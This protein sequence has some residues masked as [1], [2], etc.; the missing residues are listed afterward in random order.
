MFT[1]SHWDLK[2]NSPHTMTIFS[3]DSIMQAT[4]RL[5]SKCT[6]YLSL[7]P[8]YLAPSLLTLGGIHSC[9][10]HSVPV[11]LS[12]WSI[13]LQMCASVCVFACVCPSICAKVLI[14]CSCCFWV[15]KTGLCVCI[16]RIH[17]CDSWGCA[18]THASVLACVA[19]GI[20]IVPFVSFW[21]TL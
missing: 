10:G 20:L 18:S 5:S 8:F 7:C 12:S 2:H 21:A 1:F 16:S 19:V 9:W 15:Y 17:F 13:N 6:T 14:D 11:L 3:C 4:F